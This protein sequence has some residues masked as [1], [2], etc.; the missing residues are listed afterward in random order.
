MINYQVN[1][2]YKPFLFIIDMIG[3]IV[4]F[5]KKLFKK[6][7]KKEDIKKI[8]IIRVDEIGDVIVTTPLISTLKKE[9]PKSKLSVL[10]KES[11]VELLKN[12]PNIDGIYVTKSWFKEKISLGEFIELIKKFRKENFDMVLDPHADPRNIILAYFCG[13]IKIGFNIRGFGFLLDF[14][15]P[16]KKKHISETIL[17][18]AKA[19]GIKKVNKKTE[20]YFSK[21]DEI[22]INNLFKKHKIKRNKLL[23][24]INPGTGRKNKEWLLKNW[25]SLTGLLI[26]K[27]NCQIIFTGNEEENKLIGK[28]IGKNKNCYNFSGKSNL[29]EL[30]A[31]IKKCDLFI[32]PDTGSLHIA[33]ALNVPLIGLFGPID[34]KIWGYSERKYISLYKKLDCSFCNMPNCIRKTEKNKCMAEIEVSDVLK[35]TD[36]LIGH[37]T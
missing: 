17:D 36:R 34:P 7:F 20:V 16:Y 35:R 15:A 27:Y 23:I 33:R 24:C 37:L 6:R 12:N 8:L 3:N 10:V 25:Q 29:L 2:K 22:K 31:L 11:T 1:W 14:V 9:F 19:V 32:A 26:K 13:K 5:Y 4:F 30:S 21:K 28:I 18:L